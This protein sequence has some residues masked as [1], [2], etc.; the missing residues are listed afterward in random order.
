MSQPKG[1][2]EIDVGFIA[3]FKLAYKEANKTGKIVKLEGYSSWSVHPRKENYH[4][5]STPEG[6]ED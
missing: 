4:A 2:T 6:K 1:K 3:A 5:G